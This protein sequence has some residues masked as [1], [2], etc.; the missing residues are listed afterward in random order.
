MLPAPLLIVITQTLCSASAQAFARSAT[1]LMAAPPRVAP[2]LC[3]SLWQPMGRTAA[4]AHVVTPLFYFVTSTVVSRAA[5]LHNIPTAEREQ[6][7]RS[8]ESTSSDHGV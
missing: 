5:H 8:F 3:R 1:T 6:R 2:A 7:R 4:D